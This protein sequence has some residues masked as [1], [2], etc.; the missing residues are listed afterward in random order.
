MVETWVGSWW[1]P[2]RREEVGGELTVGES[3][4]SL[5]LFGSFK[6]WTADELA[7]GVGFPLAEPLKEPL[8][9]GHAGRTRFTLLDLSCTFPRPPGA[10]GTERWSAEAAVEG[11]LEVPA[12]RSPP[13]FSGIQAILQ[14]LGVWAQARGVD[15]RVSTGEY[16][17]E[18]GAEP[19]TLSSALLPSGG[20]IVIEQA[21]ATSLGT[22]G[23]TIHQP[24]FARMEAPARLNWQGLLDECLQPLQVLLW[25]ATA[26]PSWVDRVD[27]QLDE[28]SPRGSRWARLW[29]PFMQPGLER[30]SKDLLPS[31]VLFFANEMPGGFEEGFA[32][33]LELWGRM[34]H[35][36]GPL[37]ARARAP[38]A[39]ADD[40]FYTAVTALEAYHRL[41]RDSDRDL[42]RRAHHARVE[43]LRYVLR[44]H[45]PDLEEWAVNATLP[46][47]R[48]PLWR[49]IMELLAKSGEVGRS[50]VGQHGDRFARE[51]EEL[52]HGQAH[53]RPA[54]VSLVSE[55]G[56]LYVA[57]SA[58]VWL[59]RLSLLMELGF[60]NDEAIRRVTRH[61]WFQWN[62][63]ELRSILDGFGA[64]LNEVGSVTG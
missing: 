39:Y 8:V 26:E 55:P 59:L 22:S 44:E 25:I 52:R 28:S 34:R 10:L 7:Q 18:V 3:G 9:Y 62:A 54:S 46:F 64:L 27:V 1:R 48:I 15:Q 61:R 16:R 24:V 36:V 49:R 17:V 41:V 57:A 47:N 6:E 43:R 45:A 23:F 20:R 63:D 38:F 33:W 31:D 42:P 12:D 21:V 29:V 11:H 51:V 14:H 30:P 13:K 32:T 37:Y 53:A 35:V 19:H 58:L 56:G 40:R 2:G 4:C 5:I 60:Q 50:L